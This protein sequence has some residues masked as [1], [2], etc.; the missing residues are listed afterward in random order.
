MSSAIDWYSGRYY[1][2]EFNLIYEGI[3]LWL[4]DE[5]DPDAWDMID[6]ATGKQPLTT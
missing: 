1:N 4:A 6:V 3:F 5:Y 2:D